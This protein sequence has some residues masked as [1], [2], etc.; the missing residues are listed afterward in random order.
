MTHVHVRGSVLG[1]RRWSCEGVSGVW[2]HSSPV[3]RSWEITLYTH[4]HIHSQATLLWRGDL[5]VG[6]NVPLSQTHCLSARSWWLPTEH[7]YCLCPYIAWLML[8]HW[9][10]REHKSS[11][12]K[13]WHNKNK[14]HSIALTQPSAPPEPCWSFRLK[15]MQSHNIKTKISAVSKSL[16]D[17]QGNV[18]R[19]D[20]KRNARRTLWERQK[21]RQ[22]YTYVRG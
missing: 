3:T 16:W 2:G 1:C 10:T 22:T 11:V 19:M 9:N 17:R 7:Y 20:S 13:T 6:G 14:M 12:E 15:I 5:L 18:A 8:D 21:E 4:I